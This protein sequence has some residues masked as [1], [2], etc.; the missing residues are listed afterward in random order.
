MYIVIYTYIYTHAKEM[1]MKKILAGIL[2][3]LSFCSYCSALTLPQG[4][5][6][7]VQAQKIIDADE[8]KEGDNVLFKTIQPIKASGK[9]IFNEGTEVNA[10]VVKRKNNGILGIS[11]ELEIGEF[12]IVSNN[13]IIRLSGTITDKGEGRYLANVGW[14]FVFPLLFIKGNDAKIFTT[15]SYILHTIED[16]DL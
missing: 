5:A 4:T 8:I 11:G 3:S 14:I 7:V 6:V 13:N 10:R 16:I 15:N 9:T 2:A 12:Q 1:S